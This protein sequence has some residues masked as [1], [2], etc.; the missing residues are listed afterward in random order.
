M[1]KRSQR[2]RTLQSSLQFK[3]FAER[4]VAH[5]IDAEEQLPSEPDSLCA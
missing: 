2:T 4:S 1:V 3:R 5:A